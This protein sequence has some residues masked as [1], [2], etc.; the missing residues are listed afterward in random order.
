MPWRLGARP[1]GRDAGDPDAANAFDTKRRWAAPRTWAKMAAGVPRLCPTSP[2]FFASLAVLTALLGMLLCSAVQA[3]T[4]GVFSYRWHDTPPADAITSADV[5][6][7][8]V[9]TGHL[10]FFFKGDLNAAVRKATQAWQKAK[11]QQPTD[12]LSDEQTVQ[13]IKDGLKE[14][15]SVGLVPPAR[16]RGGICDRRADQTHELR[17][18]AHRRW[19]SLLLRR[20]RGH[21]VDRHPSRFSDL[22]DIGRV[23]S[24][25]DRRCSVAHPRGQLVRRRVQPRRRQEL[26]EGEVSSSRVDHHGDERHRRDAGEAPWPVL[27][28]GQQPR[29]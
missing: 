8:L 6:E 9:W 25:C 13:L 29:C 23:L 18:A 28:H 20:R 10:D 7:A 4:A 14:R 12:K 27:C 15:D 5:R 2:S 26:P 3:Q 21:P 22:P 16:P 1:T 19:H 24:V 17:H 11:G